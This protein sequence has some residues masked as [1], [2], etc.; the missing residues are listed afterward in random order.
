V[1][2]F[3]GLEPLAATGFPAA[4]T[5]RYPEPMDPATEAELRRFYEEPNRRLAELLGRPPLWGGADHQ[6]RR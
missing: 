3:V 4:N 2:R 1:L 5:G 6:S